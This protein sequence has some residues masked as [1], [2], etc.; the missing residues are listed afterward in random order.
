MLTLDGHDSHETQELIR[1]A[2][3]HNVIIILLPSKTTHK[4][5]PLD[6][7]VFS[8]VQRLWSK[9]CDECLGQG[10]HINRFNFIP[11]Y[12]A[13]HCTIAPSLVQK[14]FANTGI[15]PLNPDIFD[16]HDYAPS[17]ASS[18][19][20]AFPPSYPHEIPL[21]ESLEPGQDSLE[22][23][24]SDHPPPPSG[25][26]S[27][28]TDYTTYPALTMSHQPMLP[29]LPLYNDVMNAT[30]KELWNFMRLHQIQC[31]MALNE[32]TTQRDTANTHCTLARHRINN[33]TKQI[34]NKAQSKCRKSKK[35]AAR[36]LTLPELREEFELKDAEDQAKEKAELEKA[37]Q[38]R[39]DERAR[40]LR[41]NEEIHVAAN[42]GRKRV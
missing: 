19:I 34:A 28:S 20:P 7:G 37:V 27:L 23:T 22:L 39:A 30:P 14:A 38:K 17:H 12:L 32:V 36:F 31:N 11:E 21:S 8:S 26:Q 24:N 42:R 41:I 33:L 25:P 13:V 5:Q 2:F 6:V 16:N 29:P 15:Y 4:L 3:D 35:T 18:S 10:V 1:A 9:H 40:M